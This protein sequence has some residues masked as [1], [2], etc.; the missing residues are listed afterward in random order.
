MLESNRYSYLTVM[1]ACVCVCVLRALGYSPLNGSICVTRDPRCCLCVR[2]CARPRYTYTYTHTHI[3][4][5]THTHTHT[6]TPVAG[7]LYKLF[8][9]PVHNLVAPSSPPRARHLFV[10]TIQLVGSFHF[11]TQHTLLNL[12]CYPPRR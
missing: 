4:T 10:C 6:H 9:L 1:Q 12:K 5:Y 3:H 2:M 7:E 8:R 11:I